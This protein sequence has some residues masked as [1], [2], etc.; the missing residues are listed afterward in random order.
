MFGYCVWYK[1]NDI[2]INNIIKDISKIVN[3]DY[4]PVHI[5]INSKLK[6]E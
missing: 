3:Y 5:T 4:F 2:R 6:L 1:I